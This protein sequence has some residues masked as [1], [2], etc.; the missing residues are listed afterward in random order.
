MLTRAFRFHCS[1]FTSWLLGHDTKVSILVPIEVLLPVVISLTREFTYFNDR[2]TVVGLIAIGS[3]PRVTQ[4][5]VLVILYQSPFDLLLFP[6][7]KHLFRSLPLITFR[8]FSTRYSSLRVLR[9]FLGQWGAWAC[10]LSEKPWSSSSKARLTI[11]A[12]DPNKTHL[13][14]LVQTNVSLVDHLIFFAINR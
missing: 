9:M 11:V 2:A 7:T 6:V 13:K 1:G 12:F 10:C 4:I 8:P 3:L 14:L 5:M